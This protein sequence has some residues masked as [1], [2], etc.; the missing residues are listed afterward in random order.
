MALVPLNAET[1][2]N[3]GFSQEDR[4]LGLWETAGP[5]RFGTEPGVGR[6]KETA[7]TS[8]T[9]GWRAGVWEQ[10]VQGKRWLPIF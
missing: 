10:G 8:V 5:T 6:P 2:G 3:G 9:R 4:T 1:G 7:L